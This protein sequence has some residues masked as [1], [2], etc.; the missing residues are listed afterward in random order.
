MWN[1]RGQWARVRWYTVA[2]W[3]K[4]IS[5]KLFHFVASSMRKSAYTTAFLSQL[6]SAISWPIVKDL[7]VVHYAYST[8]APLSLVRMFMETI[9]KKRVLFGLERRW[10][11]RASQSC[12]CFFLA[13]V[14][15]VLWRNLHQHAFS[16][17][18]NT[19]S[20]LDKSLTS[21]ENSPPEP[22]S[23]LE[24]KPKIIF[25]T[26]RHNPTRK[27]CYCSHHPQYTSL[28]FRQVASTM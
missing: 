8:K 10:R 14:N 13:Q 17:L 7:L 9:N 22:N 2:K 24:G 18:G 12:N 4:Q 1:I 25:K 27:S 15:L 26:N 21:H 11:K 5:T 19:S 3:D 16:I 28:Y 23:T 20:P 6:T